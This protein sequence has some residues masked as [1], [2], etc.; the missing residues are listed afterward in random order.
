[1]FCGIWPLREHYLL[2]FFLSS[3]NLIFL[4]NE[5][6][7]P[8][9]PLTVSTC[10]PSLFVIQ[11]FIAILFLSLQ[12][13]F[14]GFVS[15]ANFF[16]FIHISCPRSVIYKMN[17]NGPNTDSY[18]IPLIPLSQTALSHK[19]LLS[20]TFKPVPYPHTWLTPIP[21][22]MTLDQMLFSIAWCRG[23]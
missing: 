18:G 23:K 2:F 10:D 5:L 8:V 19:Q 3:H 11:N 13:L 20:V 17:K 6:Q 4:Y 15:S 22:L 7:M 14:S 12:A 21:C 9:K 1:M 16:T